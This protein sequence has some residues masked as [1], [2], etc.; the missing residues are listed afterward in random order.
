MEKTADDRPQLNIKMPKSLKRHIKTREYDFGWSGR[1]Q[2]IAALVVFE[3]M[4]DVSRQ[5]AVS[6]ATRA[7]ETEEAWPNFVKAIEG[8][9]ESLLDPKAVRRTIELLA[10]RVGQG[11]EVRSRASK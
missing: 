9:K 1:M 6:I 5:K 10:Q 7:A 4:D 2:V 11:G 8:V 3:A